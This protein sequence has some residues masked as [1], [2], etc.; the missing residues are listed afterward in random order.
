M[1]KENK[2]TVPAIITTRVFN[3]PKKKVFNA[4]S[5]PELLAQWWGPKDFSNT[6]HVFEFN[7][8]GQWKFTMHGPGGTDFD[9]VCKFIEIEEPDKI[10]LEHVEPVHKF[11]VTST[12][13]ELNNCTRLIFSM[14]FDL[15]SEYE[16]LKDFIAAAN[17]ENFDRLENVL[18]NQK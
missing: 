15:L 4:W 8:G 7:A 16:K 14:Q 12:F 11:K 5:D 9:N 17:E 13:E 2:E 3:H 18:L 10:I 1:L 6:F